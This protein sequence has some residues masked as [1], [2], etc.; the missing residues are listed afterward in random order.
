MIR[1]KLLAHLLEAIR[2]PRGVGG[3]D[4]QGEGLR[5]APGPVELVD[6]PHRLGARHLEAAAREA[7]GHSAGE[8]RHGEEGDEPG[9]DDPPAPPPGGVGEAYE[10]PLHGA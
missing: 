6:H 10:Q 1:G 8:R 3:V 9:A 7:V 2:G 4:D 5:T